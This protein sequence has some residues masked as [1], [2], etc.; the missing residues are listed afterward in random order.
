MSNDEV[1]KE[2]KTIPLKKRKGVLNVSL[3]FDLK[4]Q[5]KEYLVIL[6]LG[7]ILGILLVK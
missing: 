6:G 5:Y 4:R 7:V 1:P 3:S 2:D